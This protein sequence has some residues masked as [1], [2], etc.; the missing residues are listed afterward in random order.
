MHRKYRMIFLIIFLFLAACST[1][2]AQSQTK[3]TKHEQIELTISAASSLKDAL[4]EILNQYDQ[5]NKNV[6]LSF[7][8]GSSGTLQ[9]QIEQGAPVDI[10]FSASHDKFDAL[11][12]KELIDK[13]Q[14]K[15][16]L[17]NDLVLVTNRKNSK[18]ISG[19]SVLRAEN[20]R[21]IAI[22]IPETVPAGKYAK[23]TLEHLKLWD[24]IQG[25]LVLAKD[26]RQVLSYVETGNIEA[27]FV[28]RTDALSSKELKIV[29]TAKSMS[30][31]PIV[32]PIGIIR[33]SKNRS[34]AEKIVTYLLTKT[35]IKVFKK[36]GF[37]SVCKNGF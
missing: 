15:E 29:S 1:E 22:G 25:K 32:Y 19:F 24:D 10:F 14:V 37:K 3:E 13:K 12:N 4:T 27:G 20:V 18:L 23:E 30:H 28:Y 33:N 6:K 21:K 35:A 31:S 5:E 7:N 8:Y 34:E 16:L 36:Y 9:R 11:V 17:M 2:S 26:V